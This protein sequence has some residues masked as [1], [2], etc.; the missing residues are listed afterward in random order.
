MKSIWIHNREFP[1]R[2]RDGVIT[3]HFQNG[4]KKNSP[5]LMGGDKGEGDP[6]F[7]FQGLPRFLVFNQDHPLPSPPPSKGE[8]DKVVKPL[9]HSEETL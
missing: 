4:I 1:H 7:I 9:L 8:G 3:I 6:G 5:P 2:F